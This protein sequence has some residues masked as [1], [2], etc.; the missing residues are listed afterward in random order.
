MSIFGIYAEFKILL[1]MAVISPN[2]LSCIT[3]NYQVLSKWSATKK[4]SISDTMPEIN[5]SHT[6]SSNKHPIA[7]TGRTI[8][9]SEINGGLKRSSNKRHI[10]R[11]GRAIT[12]LNKQ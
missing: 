2:R 5:G 1:V 12:S 3:S 10:A 9:M 6:Q 7:Q 8:T 4:I 11:T